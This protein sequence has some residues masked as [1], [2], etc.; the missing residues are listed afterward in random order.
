M[1]DSLKSHNPNAQT[2]EP[3]H[4]H[5][6]VET[7]E[8]VI[9]GF[10][11]VDILNQILRWSQQY[12]YSDV[13]ITSEQRILYRRHRR[14]FVSRQRALSESQVADSVRWLSSDGVS[15][16]ALTGDFSDFSYRTPGLKTR[17]DRLRF[18]VNVTSVYS[19]NCENALAIVM[20]SVAGAPWPLNHHRLPND[21][22]PALFNDIGL[23]LIAGPMGSG[24]T[25]LAASIIRRINE[26]SQ[27]YIV[28]FE[29]PIEYDMSLIEG[30]QI[31]IA[32]TEIKRGVKSFNDA[33]ANVT[34]RSAD[35]IFWGESRD[36]DSIRSLTIA[37]DLGAAIYSTV[38]ANSVANIIPRLVRMFP[39]EQRDGQQ[40]ALISTLQTL[41]FQ[42]LIP[43]RTKGL[44]ALREWLIMTDR[45]RQSLMDVPLA[46]ITERVHEAQLKC[47][48]DAV[49]SLKDLYSQQQISR[50]TYHALL[51]Q[52][53]SQ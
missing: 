35:V 24:K 3:N 5:W 43:H 37:C 40:A 38:H 23:N 4:P 20:R 28:T 33:L 27:R 46:Q 25:T 8:P 31:P 12:G 10:F 53:R 52:Q 47:R 16:R 26:Q 48:S 44:V 2:T 45:L 14:T 6:V 11:N 22:K 50:Q 19:A 17:S 51:R 13:I 29:D 1:T 39:A 34:R 49:S 42:R 9:D 7:D 21:L 41:I 36:P 18:R 30:T 32:Q 15:I